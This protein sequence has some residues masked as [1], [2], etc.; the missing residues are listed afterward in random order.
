MYAHAPSRTSGVAPAGDCARGSGRQVPARET[1]G[2]HGARVAEASVQLDERDVVLHVV[3]HVVLRVDLDPLRIEH[4][5]EP[6][7]LLKLVIPRHDFEGGHG[8]A[9]PE[10]KRSTKILLI[11]WVWLSLGWF[12]M[13]SFSSRLHTRKTCT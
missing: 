1:D 5:L 9:S 12:A 7:V 2:R 13:G 3:A 6:V 10:I 11:L 8:A 4:L